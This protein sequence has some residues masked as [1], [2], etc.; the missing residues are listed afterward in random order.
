MEKV[1]KHNV[2]FPVL[3][4][5]DLAVAYEWAHGGEGLHG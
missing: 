3:P 2:L 4:Q 1:V 5:F